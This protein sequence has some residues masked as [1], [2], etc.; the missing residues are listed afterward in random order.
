[1][2]RGALGDLGTEKI[3]MIGCD[4]IELFAKYASTL[5]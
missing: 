5:S 1:M 3:E 2:D 4:L